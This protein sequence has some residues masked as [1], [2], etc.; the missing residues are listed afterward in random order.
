MNKSELL[1]IVC[2]ENL[3]DNSINNPK[4]T[5][6]SQSNNKSDVGQGLASED[7]DAFGIDAAG[8]LFFS[9]IGNF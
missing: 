2:A 6:S 3:S 5:T 9:S 1:C 4:R 8:D 7:V